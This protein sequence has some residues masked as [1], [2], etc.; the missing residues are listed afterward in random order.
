MPFISFF[1]VDI[2]MLLSQNQYPHLAM[3]CLGGGD[4]AESHD[5]LTAGCRRWRQLAAGGGGRRNEGTRKGFRTRMDFAVLEVGCE[6][7]C[8]ACRCTGERWKNV[9]SFWTR[10]RRLIQWRGWLVTKCAITFGTLHT[11]T[12]GKVGFIF[13]VCTLRKSYI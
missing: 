6:Q 10:W 3:C 1:W 2:F 4:G 11:A 13:G 7:F 5:L 9:G 8:S 12:I